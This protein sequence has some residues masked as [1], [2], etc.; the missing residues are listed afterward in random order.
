MNRLLIALCI[1]LFAG[2]VL[3]SCQNSKEI[4][5]QINVL[6]TEVKTLNTRVNA[7]SDTTC[8]IL[9]R[10]FKG[11]KDGFDAYKES[12]KPHLDYCQWQNL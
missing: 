12:K 5:T 1:F 11:D 8:D 10:M 3:T 2:G 4:S 9:N 7:Y 6:T